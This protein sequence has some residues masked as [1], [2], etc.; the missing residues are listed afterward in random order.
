MHWLSWDLN[1]KVRLIGELFTHTLFWMFFPYMA[2]HFSESFGKDIAGLILTV[3][4]LLGIFANLMGGYLAD[5]IGRKRTMLLGVSISTVM[6]ALFT[7]SP[8]PWVDYIAF[9]GLGIAGSLFWPASSAMVADLTSEEER[10][11]VFA[12]FYTSMNIG[13]VA[14][15]V[16][17]SFFFIHH[18]Q[19]LML[20]CTI[21][22]LVYLIAI[23]FL[24]KES[25][26]ESVKEKGSTSFSLKE[27][28]KNYAV[29]FRDK[30]FALYILAGV[31]IAIT[32]MQLDLYMAL[33]V[34]EHV[35][36]QTLLAFNTWSM[37]VGGTEAFGWLMGLNGLLVVLFTLPVTR[38]FEGWSD[39]NSLILSSVLFGLG[40]FLMGFTTN[41]WFLFGCMG[42]LTLGELIRTPVVQSFVS[43]YAP[44]DARGQYMGA[45]TL[46]FSV[47]RFI[48]PL[49]IG[50]SAWMP[51]L[52]VFGVIFGCA[53]L[54]VMLYVYMFRRIPGNPKPGRARK[55]PLESL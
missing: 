14:G 23:Y 50:L 24:V 46:Q 55:T 9:I 12:T 7:C 32:F 18:R 47:G 5:R 42:I 38:W 15:P 39:R 22:E 1:L 34:K 44:E 43:K 35:P 45:S 54:S 33:Y 20:T 27:Q 25:L 28:W 51:P 37:S 16:L 10:R 41:I 26:P 3:P 30:V 13:V 49:T 21:F 48:A 4:P 52:G 6:F 29:I 17:G 36:N 11:V 8:S 19:E 31:L 40:F 53:L 2:L